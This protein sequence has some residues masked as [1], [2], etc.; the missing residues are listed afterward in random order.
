M[1]TRLTPILRAALTSLALIAANGAFSAEL[2]WA[3]DFSAK[4]VNASGTL[5]TQDSP[6]KDGYYLITSLSGTRNGDTISALQTTGTAIPGNAGYPVDN[7][8]RDAKPHLSVHGLG[9][10]TAKGDFSNPF[11]ADFHQPPA[12]LEFYSIRPLAQAAHGDKA[13]A[14]STEL[15]VSFNAHRIPA[16]SSGA[17]TSTDARK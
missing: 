5:T 7:L 1:P 3:W 8:I 17:S 12:Y 14:K 9:F 6:D 4:G 10:A 11:Y 16:S 2:L 13:S 15:S